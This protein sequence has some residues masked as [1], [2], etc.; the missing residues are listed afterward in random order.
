MKRNQ[1]VMNSGRRAAVLEIKKMEG[2]FP[3]RLQAR[4]YVVVV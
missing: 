3:P 4:T 2:K 1:T